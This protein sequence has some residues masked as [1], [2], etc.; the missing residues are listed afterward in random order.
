MGF[1][2]RKRKAE[3]RSPKDNSDQIRSPSLKRV[4]SEKPRK[5]SRT[6]WIRDFM[7]R[8]WYGV[9]RPI[10]S[11]TIRA[12]PTAPLVPTHQDQDADRAMMLQD[13]DR[14]SDPGNVREDNEPL[15]SMDLHRQASLP[16]EEWVSGTRK[17]IVLN[18]HFSNEISTQQPLNGVRGID[19]MLGVAS[20]PSNAMSDKHSPSSDQAPASLLREYRGSDRGGASA[21]MTHSVGNYVLSNHSDEAGPSTQQDH[22][23]T[24]PRTN[25]DLPTLEELSGT[26]SSSDSEEE[27]ADHAAYTT[28]SFISRHP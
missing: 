11:L 20:T 16:S 27:E 15:H 18:Q 23:C 22:L 26:F 2:S 1:F 24:V 28:D 8:F 6:P 10:P 12:P 13:M 21:R 3:T 14:W 25:P 17:I 9:K 4:R 19:R 5:E 7:R